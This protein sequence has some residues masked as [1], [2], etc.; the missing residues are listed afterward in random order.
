MLNANSLILSVFS[1]PAQV[2]LKYM[3]TCIFKITSIVFKL[4]G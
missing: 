4:C 1:P 3:I 2:E